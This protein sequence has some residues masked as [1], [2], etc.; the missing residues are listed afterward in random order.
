MLFLVTFFYTNSS[1]SHL[2][3][4]REPS[5]SM[6]EPAQTPI[7]EQCAHTETMEQPVLNEMYSSNP[8]TQ[9]SESYAE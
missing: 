9:E 5:C 6:C 2:A 3:I 7:I 1:V 4:I 8:S